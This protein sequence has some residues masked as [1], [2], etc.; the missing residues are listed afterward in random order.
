MQQVQLTMILPDLTRLE[1][2][3]LPAGYTH[4]T[5]RPGEQAAWDALITSSFQWPAGPHFARMMAHDPA[6]DFSRVHVLCQRDVPVATASAWRKIG[7]PADLGVIH[8]VGAYADHAGRGLGYQVVLAALHDL[9]ERGCTRAV[10]STD[11]FR[12]SAIATYLKLGFV[13]CLGYPGVEGVGRE[14]LAARWQAIGE[15][16]NRQIPPMLPYVQPVLPAPAVNDRGETPL[17]PEGAVPLWR[18]DVDQQPPFL[19]ASPLPGGAPKAAVIVAPG[20]G[21]TYKEMTRE[22]TD[23]AAHLNQMGLA[24]FTLSY[25]VAPYKHP[26]PL[27]DMQRAVRFVRAHAAHYNIDPCRVAVMGFSAGGHLSG[28]VSVINDPG[29]PAAADPVA[30]FGCEPAGQVLCYPFIRLEPASPYVILDTLVEQGGDFHER[31]ARV[32]VHRHVTPATCP[33]FIWHTAEDEMVP[34]QNVYDMA[35]ALAKAGVPCELHVYPHGHHGLDWGQGDRSV[36]QWHDAL[37]V[38]FEG[39]HFIE[40]TKG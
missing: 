9:R 8:M 24:A 32:S 17:W 33:A 22:G 38:W 19:I 2:L 40:T 3:C 34:V 27:M 23:I 13:P 21:Y 28:C 29:D 15:C 35:G 4:R 30:R 25:R 31:S 39:M 37:G 5:L 1:P 6:L 10:L 18:E 26:A 7:H 16:L 14:G 20:G 12:L 36:S 11:D